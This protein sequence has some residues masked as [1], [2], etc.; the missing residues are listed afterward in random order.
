MLLI[1]SSLQTTQESNECTSHCFSEDVKKSSSPS[2]KFSNSYLLSTEK[3]TNLPDIFAFFSNSNFSAAI[4]RLFRF[5]DTK[6]IWLLT[7]VTSQSYFFTSRPAP[8]YRT[9][10]TWQ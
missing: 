5:P 4:N 3:G 2:S 1:L 6:N 8:P 10:K 9:M 7:S